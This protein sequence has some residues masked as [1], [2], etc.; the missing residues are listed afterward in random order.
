MRYNNTMTTGL[1]ESLG[2]RIEVLRERNQL[3]RLALDREFQRLADLR[4]VRHPAA[5]P[6]LADPILNE[7][8]PRELEVL[9]CIAEGCSTKETAT[10]LDISFK[11]AACHRHRVMQ[12]VGVHGT[13]A[14][15][16]FA[17]ANRVVKLPTR[18]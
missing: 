17:I 16:R 2:Q 10:R 9:R 3:I 4:T 11:T 12:K 8:T 13:G 6:R 14:L 5:P 7:L 18:V 15:V 1:L